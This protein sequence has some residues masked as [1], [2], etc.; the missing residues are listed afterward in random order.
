MRNKTIENI[1]DEVIEGTNYSLDFKSALKCFIKNKFDNNVQE[2]DL[3]RI[4]SLLNTD[5]LTED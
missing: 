2:G 5:E 3:K 1:I 4:L